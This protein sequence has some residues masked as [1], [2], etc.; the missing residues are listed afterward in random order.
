MAIIRFD[1][2][3]CLPLRT[4]EN[5]AGVVVLAK[6]SVCGSVDISACKPFCRMLPRLSIGQAY[7]AGVFPGT[8]HHWCS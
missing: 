8:S 1:L 5:L 6:Q 2:A 7:S 3:R 4:L